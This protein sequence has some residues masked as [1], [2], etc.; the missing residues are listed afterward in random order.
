MRKVILFSVLTISAG[1]LIFIIQNG[2]QIFQ[3]EKLEPNLGGFLKL[4]R[5]DPLFYSP[6]FNPT[7]FEKAIEGLR[8]SENQL[9]QAILA[10]LEKTTGFE[11]DYYIP[12]LKENNLFSYQFLKNLILI[13][14]K[15]EEFLKNPSIEGGKNLLE[16]YDTTA[17]SY[18]QDISS[19]IKVLEEIEAKK[20]VISHYFFVDSVTSFEVAKNDFLT[21]RE[22]GYKLKEVIEKRESCLLG[23]EDCLALLKSKDNSS[24]INLIESGDFDL[25]GEKIDFI[26][27]LLPYYSHQTL[28]RGPYKIKSFCWQ[29][30]NF[31]HWLY[32]IYVEQNG[33]TIFIPK[34]A[35]RNYYRRIPPDAQTKIERMFLEKGLEFYIQPEA[36]TY[37]CMDITFY[38]K[39][40]TLDFLKEKMETG[41]ISKKDLEKN[42]D[43]KLLI[44]NQF[45]LIVP[46]IN[47]VSAH[48]GTLKSYQLI[49]E[50]VIAPEALFS[51]RTTYSIFYFPFAKS[52]WRV[53]K[54][55]QY[56][57]PEE[58]RPLKGPSG[59]VTL[60]ELI[61]M[62]YPK[63]EIE[64][65]H[66]DIRKFL[67]PLLREETD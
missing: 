34:L 4:T 1:F 64:K 67:N 6:F 3:R 49:G 15:T 62:G 14:Q 59:F 30:P 60:D 56:F 61:E 33:R 53:D 7:E 17:N 63:K 29:N 19:K 43:Y 39:L 48:L 54:E 40:L 8:E 35:N 55:L 18:I 13:N 51:I 38:P 9:K 23:K 50:A 21:I 24:F 37:E 5:E 11:K 52:I 31:E 12:I 36:A 32:L 27:N 20:T 28:V 45:G 58:K 42:L 16:L 44:E 25:K 46:A 41:E 66:I 57:V 65:F 47:T 22:N 2:G 10:N 26:K